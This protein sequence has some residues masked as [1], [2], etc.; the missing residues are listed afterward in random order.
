MTMDGRSGG[1]FTGGGDAPGGPGGGDVRSPRRWLLAVA[2]AVVAVVLAVAGLAWWAGRAGAPETAGTVARA[3]VGENA[4]GMADGDD[5]GRGGSDAVSGRAGTTV[6]APGAGTWNGS[7]R[8]LR[9]CDRC[10]EMVVIPAGEFRMGSPALEEGRYR[11]EGPQHRVTVSSFAL[12][13]TEVTFDE[14]DACVRD[15]GCEGYRPGD[16][17]WGRGAR[18]VINV[19][20]E[21]AQ[22]YVSWL[23][24]ETG[25]AYRLPSESEWEYA[26]RAGTTTPFHTGA[27]ISTDQANYYGNVVYGSGRRGTYRGETTPV[28]TF[29]PNAFGLYDV[30]GNV[31]EWVEDCWHDSYRG[32]PSDGTAWMVG[33]D[34]GRRVLRGGTWYNHPRHL[35]SAERYW[36]ATG[37][38]DSS[39]GFRVARTLD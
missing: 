25:A 20:W 19:S 39:A 32:A 18:P 27:T 1:D 28:G 11:Y 6:V 22:A 21:D 10:P 17:G 8:V 4:A 16:E 14:W 31:R 30:H 24:A 12:G 23:S 34:C 9:D 5:G 15:S 38:W 7:E 33:G 13:V 37:F 26:A 36:I 29:A 3:P 2:A 35:R